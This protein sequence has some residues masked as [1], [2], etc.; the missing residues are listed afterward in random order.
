LTLGYYFGFFSLFLFWF[1]VFDWFGFVLVSF[2]EYQSYIF[3]LLFIFF[4]IK[5]NFF[6]FFFFFLHV[7]KLSSS[8]SLHAFSSERDSCRDQLVDEAASPAS[9]K[10]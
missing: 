3:F 4:P 2:W 6:I 1:G 7:A 8:E 9:Q 5:V 10:I